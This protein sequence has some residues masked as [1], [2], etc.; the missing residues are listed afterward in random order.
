MGLKN[1]AAVGRRGQGERCPGL[2]LFIS[3]HSLCSWL[4]GREGGG[5]RE[6]E[7]EPCAC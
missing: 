6:L 5:L 7:A 1:G 4:M 2:S 3:P